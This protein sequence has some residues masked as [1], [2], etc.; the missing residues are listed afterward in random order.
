MKTVLKGRSSQDTKYIN[1]HVIA[2]LHAV[3]LDAF[4]DFFYASVIKM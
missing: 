1:K 3:A 2:D 4:D